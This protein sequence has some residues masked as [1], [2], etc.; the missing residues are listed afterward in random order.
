MI[1]VSRGCCGEEELAQVKEAFEYGYFG[2]AYKVEEF[3]KAIADYLTTNRNI[4]ATNTGTSALHLALAT[5]GIGGGDEVILPSFTFVATA[6]TISETGAT[7]V[8]C[9]VHPDTFLL[10]LE[11][12]KRKITS[13][14]KAI[15]PVHLYG[16]P[17]NMDVILDIAKRHNLYVIE[18]ACQ[19]IGARL[20]GKMVGSFGDI[21]CF[22]FYPTKN[23]GGMGDGGLLTT[24]SDVIKDRVLALRNH[25]GA[26]R[27]HH[28]EIGV[29]SRLDEVQAAI[30]RVKLNYINEW[31]EARR[32]H[33]K[34]YNEL[35]ANCEDVQ[36]P[37]ELD[38]TYCVYHQ[39]TVKIPNRDNIHKMLQER[40]IGAMLYYPIPLHLQ[41]VHEYLG[42]GKGS[43]PNT[44]K[45]TEMVI[46][47]PMFPEITLEEQ[48]TVANTLME[49]IQE[50]KALA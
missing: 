44:E 8:F 47:L 26:V 33:A 14:T 42:M 25:G 2:L 22:S 9:D 34:T 30:L 18:D 41:K 21:G 10:D 27:Y 43:L 50:T 40:G 16:Q 5:L 6:Q 3:E 36:T 32:A 45:D 20:H 49:C 24:N 37:T 1:K 19:A 31:N 11:D 17:A 29:N 46:S 39:Y 28:D 23:L 4:V 12:V 35:F 7:P 38:D 13:R 48:K 15:I